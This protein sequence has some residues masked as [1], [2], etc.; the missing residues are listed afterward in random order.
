MSWNYSQNRNAQTFSLQVAMDQN[1][2]ETL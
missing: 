1:K 2:P